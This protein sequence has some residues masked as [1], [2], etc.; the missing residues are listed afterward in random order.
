MKICLLPHNWGYVDNFQPV[1]DYFIKHGIDY[2]ILIAAPRNDAYFKFKDKY[3][4]KLVEILSENLAH[5]LGRLDRIPLIGFYLKTIK[6]EHHIKKILAE[7]NYSIIIASCDRTYY[8]ALLIKCA[9]E[10]NKKIITIL[11]PTE[12]VQYVENLLIS[13]AKV[14]PVLDFKKSILFLLIKFIFPKNFQMINGREIAY[15]PPRLALKLLSAKLMSK[16]PWIRGANRIDTVAVNSREQ[17]LENAK[18]GMVENLMAITGFPPHD[19]IYKLIRNS[20]ENAVKFKTEHNID[21]SKK[22]FVV[23]GTHYAQFF[24]EQEWP[25]LDGEINRVAETIIATLGKDY[26]IVFKVHPR[27]SLENQKKIFTKEAADKIIFIQNEYNAYELISICDATL[28]FFSST[29]IGSLGIEA[30][31][32]AYK[33]PNMPGFELMHDRF[34]SVIQLFDQQQLLDKLNLMA[35]GKLFDEKMKN[36]REED[37]KKFV[38]FDG[39]N[40]ERFIELIGL[41]HPEVIR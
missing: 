3:G 20:A 41:C 12:D 32:F 27:M 10:L 25:L 40:T 1:I 22:I 8:P 37:R 24:N 34:K 29:L 30:P 36:L 31:I 26:G 7:K 16:N 28:N 21:P 17:Y 14:A 2:D 13:R 35:E 11:Y 15:T 18:Y 23:M 9:K 4:D 39:K 6:A 19:E 5:E 38:I 33:M